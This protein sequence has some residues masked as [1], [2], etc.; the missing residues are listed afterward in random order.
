VTDIE[1]LGVGHRGEVEKRPTFSA[2]SGLPSE[3]HPAHTGK[4]KVHD[5]DADVSDDGEDDVSDDC[6]KLAVSVWHR[7]CV[8]GGQ[9]GRPMEHVCKAGRR[10]AQLQYTT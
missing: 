7:R 8:L 6:V 2:S 5:G 10:S 9:L 1:I 3:L 4:G